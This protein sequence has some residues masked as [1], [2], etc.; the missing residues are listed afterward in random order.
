[1]DATSKVIV[2][3]IG[4]FFLAIA[5]AVAIDFCEMN[6]EKLYSSDSKMKKDE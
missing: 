5:C 3:M 2:A 1:M 4:F 6:R